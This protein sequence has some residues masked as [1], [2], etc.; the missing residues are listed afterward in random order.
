VTLS[1]VSPA[2]PPQ[3]GPAPHRPRGPIGGA[4]TRWRPSWLGAC[5]ACAEALAAKRRAAHERRAA[6]GGLV[7]PK[8]AE[9]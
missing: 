1:A 7:S 2:A 8:G 3:P 5:P 6:A 9:R 4:V